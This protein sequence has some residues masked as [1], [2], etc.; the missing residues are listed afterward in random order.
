[1][2]GER[3]RPPDEKLEGL[4]LKQTLCSQ[5]LRQIEQK[6]EMLQGFSEI[7]AIQ[8]AAQ[9]IVEESYLNDVLF[10]IARHE[11]EPVD[12]QLAKLTARQTSH[13]LIRHAQR[14]EYLHIKW[15]VHS[16]GAKLV[17]DGLK[18]AGED[19][20]SARRNLRTGS[21]YLSLAD[22]LPQAGP[23]MVLT[24]DPLDEAHISFDIEDK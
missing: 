16:K 2:A 24:L 23:R 18:S 4:K 1:M 10:R 20:Q 9:V 14:G 5:R 6:M 12:V 17:H 11:K 22:A 15:Y 13:R 8:F 21:L 3:Y 19:L 7:D